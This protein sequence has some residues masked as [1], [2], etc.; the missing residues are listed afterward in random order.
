MEKT[1]GMDRTSAC[2]RRTFLKGAAGCGA[3]V[4]WALSGAPV[5]VRRA[6]AGEVVEQ[7]VATEAFARVEQVAENA[8]AVISTPEGGFV[9][10][11]NGGIIAG[12]DAVLA[13]E[14]YMTPKGGAWLRGVAKELTGR[15]PTHL[16][17][18]H[19]HGD[20]IAGAKG[21]LGDEGAGTVA[22]TQTVHNALPDALK[23]EGGAT[24]FLMLDDSAPTELDLGGR[25]VRM[26][27]RQG[28]TPSDLAIELI[29]PKIVWCGDLLWNG[30]FPNY[31]D[32]LPSTLATQCRELLGENG[33]VYIPGHGPI[34]DKQSNQRYL[35]MLD[36]VGDAARIAHEKGTPPAEA[37]KDFAIPASLGEWNLFQPK[38]YQTAFEAWS[39]ELSA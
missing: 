14:G 34:G 36:F 20:H 35:E 27:P 29:D 1:I 8:W 4:M 2:C 16:A 7:A 24:E 21:V 37:A 26:T 15:T 39:R 11:S 9:T 25:T 6:F 13:I 33:G 23:A 32:A 12:D 18:T 31:V 30:M 3:Y 22:V 19:F 10:V 28:H 38:F 5:G 17:L